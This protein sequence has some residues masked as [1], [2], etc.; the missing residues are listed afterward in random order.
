MKRRIFI[1][2]LAALTVFLA[3]MWSSALV[4]FIVGIVIAYLLDP[5]VLYAQRRFKIKRLPALLLVFILFL[6][7]FLF[8]FV[9]IFPL[10]AQGVS[11]LTQTFGNNWSEIESFIDDSLDWFDNLDLPIDRETLKSGISSKLESFFTQL[12]GVISSFVL[13]IIG[14]IP[15]LIIIPLIVFYLLKDKEAIFATLKRYTRAE[16]EVRVR[17]FFKDIDERLGGYIKGQ[18]LLSALVT[19]ITFIAL[20]IFGTPYAF[21]IA[22]ANGILNII[23]YFG[24]VIGAIPPVVLELIHFS[25]TGHL[26]AVIVFFVAMNILVSALVS[27]KIFASATN[28]HPV[29]VLLAIFVGSHA[30]GMVGMI[31]AVPFAIVIQTLIRAIFDK[32]IKEI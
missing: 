23:P 14:S 7:L 30:M 11:A 21:L 17:T 2:V 9:S 13:S 24:P 5:L 12:F 32:Y 28:L 31:V 19:A 16:N 26:I 4:P 3:F 10:L 8:I 20:L 15:L 27:P 22:L 6:L 29:F 25:S 1:S 18:F